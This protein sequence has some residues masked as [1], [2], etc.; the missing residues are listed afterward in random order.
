MNDVAISR[1]LLALG[2]LVVLLIGLRA[3]APN[4]LYDNDQ[5]EQVEFI[6]DAAINGNWLVQYSVS[7]GDKEERRVTPKPPMYT[8]LG[9]VAVKATGAHATWVYMAPAIG[10]ALVIALLVYHFV[11]P[12]A[13]REAGVVGVAVWLSSYH[14]YKLVYTA[15]TDMLLAMWIGLALAVLLRM[16]TDWLGGRKPRLGWVFL[17][18][19]M[20]GCG[21]LTKG[22]IAALPAVFA[23]ALVAIDG[24]WLR[25]RLGWQ[26]V[27]LAV[28]FVMYALWFYPA[29]KSAEDPGRFYWYHI[30]KEH[31]ERV[32]GGETSRDRHTSTFAPVAYFFG[33]WLPWSVLFGAAVVCRAWLAYR[34][35]QAATERQRHPSGYG[36]A[37]A[38]MWVALVVGLFMAPKGK[39]ADYIV[40]AYLGASVAC[41]CFVAWVTPKRRYRFDDAGWVVHWLL[42]GLGG[43]LIAGGAL[44]CVPLETLAEWLAERKI[45]LVNPADA[46]RYVIMALAGATAVSGLVTLA[47]TQKRKY[48]AAVM[49]GAI[50][51]VLLLGIYS[52]TLSRAAVSQDGAQILR[53]VNAVKQQRTG[54]G[55]MPFVL[56]DT[57]YTPVGALLGV[58]RPV[59]DAAWAWQPARGPYVLV[60]RK[61]VLAEPAVAQRVAGLEPIAETHWMSEPKLAL[62]AFVVPGSGGP[63]RP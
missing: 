23:L 3:A 57:G 31:V 47:F 33:R 34:Y 56:Y 28:P 4:D 39:R 43:A 1:Y 51:V 49:P 11:A 26:L 5:T 55:R 48:C 16:R 37:W 38:V 18:W 24:A 58:H 61:A 22:P 20:I 6:N 13:G 30:T 15:R 60:T 35:G 12:L 29:W 41:A 2:V 44:F 50:G 59:G 46:P 14:V 10:A 25:A 7:S 9:A 27:G 42:L 17:F 54:E 45:G 21:Y 19:A 52:Q 63:D 8:W 40:P 53:L 32:F 62:V 36:V